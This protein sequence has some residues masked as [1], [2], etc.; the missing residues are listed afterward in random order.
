MCAHQKG[1]WSQAFLA[2]T[3]ET[4]D[5]NSG[6]TDDIFRAPYMF[7]EKAQET[8]MGKMSSFLGTGRSTNLSIERVDYFGISE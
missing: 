2:E 7:C 6:V 8:L 4:G 5:K 3:L 1:S